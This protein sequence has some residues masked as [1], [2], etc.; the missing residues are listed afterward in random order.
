MLTGSG[1]QQCAIATTREKTSRSGLDFNGSVNL[2][3]SGYKGV[4]GSHARSIGFW[5]V[6]SDQDADRTMIDFGDAD[7]G[8][9]WRIYTTSAGGVVAVDIDDKVISGSTDI[10]DGNWNHVLVSFDNTSSDNFSAS[11]LSIYVNGIAET[12]TES[13]SNDLDVDT[14]NASTALTIGSERDGSGGFIGQLAS[15]KFWERALSASMVWPE[16]LTT[17][18]VGRDA[19]A[20]EIILTDSI[21][22]ASTDNHSITAFSDPTYTTSP[23]PM[24]ARS[25]TGS[26]KAPTIPLLSSYGRSNISTRPIMK[27]S[28]AAPHQPRH[29]A[30][31]SPI[32]V[33]G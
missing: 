32:A 17:N 13:N 30:G 4:S 33:T 19:L 11:T 26:L 9:R 7:A 21:S 27:R 15:I 25:V 2:S 31:P 6:Q 10:V 5:M 14:D 12:L 1:G 24:P 23:V 3:L 22:D 18:A 20:V 28:T 8:E 29:R 16:V